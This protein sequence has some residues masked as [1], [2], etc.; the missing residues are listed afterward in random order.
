MEINQPA[1]DFELPDLQGQVHRLGEAR[2][3]VAL[4]DF[5]SAECPWVARV[6]GELLPAVRAWGEAVHL[7]MVAAN[8]SEGDDL[9][10]A[11]AGARGIPFVLRASST[12]LDRYGVEITPQLFVV[13]RDG[14][15][16]YSGAFDDVTFRQ[17]RAERRYLLEAVEAVLAG[18]R[19]DPARTPP[20]GCTVM[21][22]APESC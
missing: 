6:D 17:R 9:L 7:L 18:R 11:A 16:R 14:I 12:V 2:G 3:R 8:A 15:L 21:R 20:Y 5:W 4:I 13:D 1:P 19:P 22:Q 10:A